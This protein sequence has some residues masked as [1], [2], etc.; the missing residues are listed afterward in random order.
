MSRSVGRHEQRRKSWSCRARG[1]DVPSRLQIPPRCEPL[2][3]GRRDHQV[4]TLGQASKGKNCEHVQHP[5]TQFGRVHDSLQHLQVRRGSVHGWPPVNTCII[6]CTSKIFHRY[7][8]Y[9]SL[10]QSINDALIATYL[11]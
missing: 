11:I 10:I 7:D 4:P 1:M 8:T 5:G 9:F 3:G 6:P 2:R